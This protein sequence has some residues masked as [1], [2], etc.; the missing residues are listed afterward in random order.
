MNEIYPQ[1]PATFY[2]ALAVSAAAH[3]AV[4]ALLIVSPSGKPPIKTGGSKTKVIWIKPS[5]GLKKT[6]KKKKSADLPPPPPVPHKVGKKP[7]KALTKTEK[8]KPEKNKNKKNKTEIKSALNEIEEAERKRLMAAALAQLQVSEEERSTE[9][10]T[11]TENQAGTD[12]AGENAG[13]DGGPVGLVELRYRSEVKERYARELG[14]LY[15][16]RFK[17]MELSATAEVHIDMTG[18]VISYKLTKRSGNPAFDAAIT[19]VLK[20]VEFLPPP[21]QELHEKA[22]KGLIIEFQ[23]R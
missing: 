23:P 20:K 11:D 3:A 16:E 5:A 15:R 17:G 4:L 13:G 21:P 6:V 10:V 9:E 2:R 7:S 1:V 19:V 8:K 12:S 14:A 18:K 22:A